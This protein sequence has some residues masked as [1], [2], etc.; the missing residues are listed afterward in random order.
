MNEQPFDPQENGFVYSARQV[1][2]EVQRQYLD[3]AAATAQ[4]AEY[5]RERFERW[6]HEMAA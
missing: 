2:A 5:N 1:A 6:H 4:K 3:S